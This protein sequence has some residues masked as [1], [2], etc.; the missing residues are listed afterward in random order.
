MSRLSSL[1]FLLTGLVS[2]IASANLYAAQEITS[3]TTT[4]DPV[5]GTT[6]V[7]EKKTIITA[8]P[9]PKVVVN[10]PVN[11][12]N[13]F[14]VSAGWFNNVW[15]DTHKVCQYANSSEGAAWVQGYWQCTDYK[16]DSGEC[17]KWDWK[18][19]HWVKTYEVY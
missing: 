18:D 7:I 6:T 10:Q 19:A 2:V 3:T 5:T 16:A 1:S 17:T 15:A 13:C 8:A 11:F 9:T 12:V 4:S 14:N